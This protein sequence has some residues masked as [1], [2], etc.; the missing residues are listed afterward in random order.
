MEQIT[1][2]F[3][4]AIDCNFYDAYEIFTEEQRIEWRNQKLKAYLEYARQNPFYQDRIGNVN[5]T[6]EHPLTDIVPIKASDIRPNIPPLG[7]SLVMT[8]SNYYTVFQ[9]GGTTG[10]PKSTLF[11]HEELINLNLP[12]TRGFFACGLTPDDRVANLFASGALYMTFIHINNMLQQYGCMNFPFT[13]HTTHD[14]IH[15]IVKHFNVNCFTGI[16]SV[17]LD[18]LRAIALLGDEDLKIEKLY[19]GGEHFYESDKKEMK[20]KL[21]IQTILAPG[22]GTVDTWYLG[23]QCTHCQTGVFHAHDDQACIEIVD[24]ETGKPCAENQAGMVYVT[25]YPRRLTPVVRYQ[26]GDIAKWT[27]KQCTCGRTTPTFKLLGRG[28]DV[29]RIGFD[30]VDYDYIQ[31]TVYTIKGLSGTV[32]MEKQRE[33]GIDRLV[34]RVESDEPAHLYENISRK[35]NDQILFTRPTFRKFVEQKLVWPLYIEILPPDSISRN[36]K[37]GKLIRVIDLIEE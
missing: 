12:N 25:T 29:L 16:S 32:Q 24:M 14:F 37:T 7:R 23:Y 21:G 20:E 19:Y 18:A 6:K 1:S 9:S 33:K 36:S 5:L 28:D 15:S 10:A 2:L 3:Q 17:C 26:V 13:N 35:L 30:S 11:S 22:Y 27:G 4:Q 8:D 31:N 34:I